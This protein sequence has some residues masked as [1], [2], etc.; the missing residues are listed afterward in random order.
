M[1]T[2]TYLAAGSAIA[3]VPS[4][5]RTI[6]VPAQ[7][8]ALLRGIHSL[9]GG[10]LVAAPKRAAEVLDYSFEI[11]ARLA[12]G[13]AIVSVAASAEPVGLPIRS[14]SGR[15]SLAT[16]WLGAARAGQ[17]YLLTIFILTLQGRY[18][19]LLVTLSIPG[20]PSVPPTHRH[21]D[22]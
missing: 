21:G 3:W 15:G 2:I 20:V 10:V 9:T 16:L 13:D 8:S 19:E 18:I 14:Q 6:I 17:S 7:S 22:P 12:A 4:P 1:T 5:D 11:G